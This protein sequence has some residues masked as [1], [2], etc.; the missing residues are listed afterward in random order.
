MC[1]LVRSGQSNV[2]ILLS[3][4]CC[5]TLVQQILQL[6]IDRSIAM[7]DWRKYSNGGLPGSLLGKP[8]L[9]Y[10]CQPSIAILLSNL[11][12]N[13]CWTRILQQR[14]DKLDLGVGIGISIEDWQ[15]YCKSKLLHG[16][17]LQYSTNNSEST[18]A[19]WLYVLLL[20]SGWT[21][22]MYCVCIFS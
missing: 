6:R 1:K 4:L 17:N 10:F 9:E 22:A 5:K 3:I 13:T 20:T 8:P 18:V 16:S 19:G 2:A 11:S 12:C 15:K 7:E 21:C 14:I